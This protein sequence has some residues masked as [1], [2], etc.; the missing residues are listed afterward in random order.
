MSMRIDV[1]WLDDDE[2][3]FQASCA[4]CTYVSQPLP[5]EDAAR[6]DWGRHACA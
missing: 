3:M 2:L 4:E 6:A 1:T 5:D